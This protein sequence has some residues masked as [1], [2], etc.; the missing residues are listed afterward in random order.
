M[1]AD[2]TG[3]GSTSLVESICLLTGEKTVM[4]QNWIPLKLF[5][6]LPAQYVENLLSGGTIGYSQSYLA[7]KSTCPPQRRVKWIWSICCSNNYYLQYKFKDFCDYINK[8]ARNFLGQIIKKDIKMTN[9]I[10][11]LAHVNKE[12]INVYIGLLGFSLFV[13]SRIF[14]TINCRQPII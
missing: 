8:L 12:T 11:P 4:L 10:Y 9:N 13:N 6:L 5:N 14:K 7:V 3:S 1:N 2:P